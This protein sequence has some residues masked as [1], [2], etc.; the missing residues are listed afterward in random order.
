MAERSGVVVI[1][2]QEGA[3]VDAASPPSGD[4]AEGPGA[5]LESEE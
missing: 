1:E 4:D 5:T 3:L 2:E